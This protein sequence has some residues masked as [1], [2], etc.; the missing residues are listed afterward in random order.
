MLNN[1]F[2]LF[3]KKPA[4]VA[5]VPDEID[6]ETRAFIDHCREPETVFNTGDD[7]DIDLPHHDFIRTCLARAIVEIDDLPPRQMSLIGWVSSVESS[8]ILTSHL[9]SNAKHRGAAERRAELIRRALWIADEIEQLDG[10]AALDFAAGFVAGTI[11]TDILRARDYLATGRYLCSAV[12]AFTEGFERGQVERLSK[13]VRS[14][15]EREAE[16]MGVEWPFNR[17]RG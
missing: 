17:R 2:R 3:K 14:H 4:P 8:F 7:G 16:A 6:E 5:P 12:K 13:I 1:V 11:Q 10:I 9:P 15:N